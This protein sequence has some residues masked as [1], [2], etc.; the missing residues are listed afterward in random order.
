Q[1]SPAGQRLLVFNHTQRQAQLWGPEARPLT[2]PIPCSD[3]AFS[4]DGRRLMT[5]AD[6]KSGKTWDVET[7]AFLGDCDA[8]RFRAER[9]KGRMIL[10]REGREAQLFDATTGRALATPMKPRRGVDYA[11]L[12]ADD[13][14]AVTLGL[15][16]WRSK[17]V[18]TGLLTRC[19]LRL[20]DATTGEP[21][22]PA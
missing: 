12:L 17:T 9:T 18:G 20:W 7:G 14:F 16:T 6:G 3:F 2:P 11:A 4:A 22:L 21:V 13:R 8:A 19:D 5:T 10:T 15:P 1:F